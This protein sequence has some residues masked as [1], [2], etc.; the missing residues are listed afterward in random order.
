MSSND[1]MH[2]FLF[3]N[4]DIRGEVV[5]LA[6]SYRQVI[7][8]NQHLPDNVKLILGE[9][10]AAVSLLSSSLKFDGLISLQIRGEGPLSLIVA[11]C[12]HHRAVRGIAQTN[13]EASFDDLA[14]TDLRQLVGKAVLAITIDPEKGKRYQGLVPVESGSLAECLQQYFAQSEQLPTHFWFAASAENVTGLMLQA[15]PTQLATVDDNQD[16]WQTV[17]QL[18]NTVKDQE[19]LTLDHAEVLY[20]LFNEENVRLFEPSAIHFECSCSSERSANSLIALGREE[21][22]NL[23]VEQT[24]IN[25]DCQFCNQSY[26]FSGDD[27]AE[28][29]GHKDQPLH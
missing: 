25:I 27:M 1:L 9:F 23:L 16:H 21:F 2:R 26:T 28:L 5:T 22:E 8:N 10:A 12:S 7:E 15:L 20:R 6:D 11:E 19:L 18:A 13:P 3:D 14:G 29:F 4:T 17:V 24:I